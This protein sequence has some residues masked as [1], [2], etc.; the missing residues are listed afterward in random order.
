MKILAIDPGKDKCG[1]AVMEKER[2]L[3]KKLL[4][5][6][7]FFAILNKLLIDYQIEKI[8][9]GDRTFSQQFKRKIEEQT[10]KSYPL[11]LVDE[12]LSTQEARFRYFQENPPRG[13][14]RCLPITLQTPSQPYDHYVAV[15]LGERYF[16]QF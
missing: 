2:V 6:E 15:I 11:I 14:K 16:Q 13:W 4:S 1:I 8:I 12:H 5:P 3:L 9:L 10:K 7:Q